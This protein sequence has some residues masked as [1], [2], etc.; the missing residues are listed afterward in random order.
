MRVSGGA[1]S[2]QRRGIPD[3]DAAGSSVLGTSPPK[4]AD[5]ITSLGQLQLRHS[6]DRASP[7]AAS[8]RPAASFTSIDRPLLSPL[9]GEHS[10]TA[11]GADVPQQAQ[12]A[13]QSGHGGEELPDPSHQRSVTAGSVADEQAAELQDQS[14]RSTGSEGPTARDGWGEF[15]G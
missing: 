12:H 6:F 3:M 10:T 4:S 14:R 13:E 15:V 9:S 2:L 7:A 1:D 11:A 5:V 8:L